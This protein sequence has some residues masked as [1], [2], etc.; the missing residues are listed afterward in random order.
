MGGGGFGGGGGSTT[1][2]YIDANYGVDMGIRKDFQIKKN[3]ASISVNWSD[4]FRSRKYIV[5]SEATGFIQD[6]WRRRD[7]QM[8]RVN[9]S[10]RF[11]K[12]DV[13]LFKRKNMR[14]EGEGMQNGMQG[15]QQ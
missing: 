4:I 7:P 8:V 2:G 5:H 12:F 1:Q 9:F 11:G 3:T 10:Y 14:G 13:A 15:M 6:D